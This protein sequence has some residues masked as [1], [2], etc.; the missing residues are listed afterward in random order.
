MHQHM[1]QLASVQ[2]ASAPSSHFP[3]SVIGGA[4]ANAQSAHM[5]P[6]VASAIPPHSDDDTMPSLLAAPF[7]PSSLA[8]PSGFQFAPAY[9]KAYAAA[10]TVNV[11]TADTHGIDRPMPTELLLFPKERPVAQVSSLP[12]DRRGG[13][14]EVLQRAAGITQYLEQMTSLHQGR[15]IIHDALGIQAEIAEG[16]Y[17]AEL[18]DVHNF[19]WPFEVVQTLKHAVDMAD[20][21][22]QLCVKCQAYLRY[23]V[24]KSA[25]DLRYDTDPHGDSTASNPSQP[26]VLLHAL[27]QTWEGINH[28]ERQYHFRWLTFGDT[29]VKQGSCLV[30][31]LLEEAMKARPKEMTNFWK[32]HKHFF[33]AM[34]ATVQL[35]GIPHPDLM[36]AR[37]EGTNAADATGAESICASM[38]EHVKSNNERAVLIMKDFIDA[39]LIGTAVANWKNEAGYSLLWDA[40]VRGHVGIALHL[41]HM[42]PFDLSEHDSRTGQGLLFHLCYHDRELFA[43]PKCQALFLILRR[44]AQSKIGMTF[45]HVAAHRRNEFVLLHEVDANIT[46]LAALDDY[47]FTPL[48]IFVRMYKEEF[49]PRPVE[50]VV[51]SDFFP[52]SFLSTK[53]PTDISFVLRND[54]KKVVHVHRVIIMY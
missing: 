22:D 21:W 23:V 11:D 12:A 34:H 20:L 49:P 30:T 37:G 16:N 33:D 43:T 26:A 53:A 7:D 15:Q 31:P 2:H 18:K 51:T 9:A 48:L 27:I 10:H 19:T 14:E 35:D 6:M 25:H 52:V 36:V 46:A 3:P 38:S 8:H 17:D 39:N 40:V 1:Q 54:T 47:N 24:E 32:A 4:N 44:A 29:Y 41:A 28:L 13:A 45:L 50:S 42:Y 5:P